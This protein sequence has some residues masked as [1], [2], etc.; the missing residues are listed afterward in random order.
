MNKKFNVTA[1]K[2]SASARSK[3]EQAGGKISE[4]KV[5]G[6]QE[7]PAAKSKVSK[8]KEAPAAEESA[9]AAEDDD[10]RSE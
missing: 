4:P 8:K 7:K 2:V 6:K 3:I 1:D 5:E 9:P 10:T